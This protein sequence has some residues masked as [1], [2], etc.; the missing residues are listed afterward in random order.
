[1]FY[2]R[3]AQSAFHEQLIEVREW[4]RDQLILSQNAME[5]NFYQKFSAVTYNKSHRQPFSPAEKYFEIRCST[6]CG[7]RVRSKKSKA[8]L[9]SKTLGTLVL[10]FLLFELRWYGLNSKTC[11]ET[12]PPKG[13]A[14][15]DN[16][17]GAHG[18]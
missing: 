13:G 15:G 5:Q 2:S 16:D 12:G 18:L 1:M 17:R 8:A 7:A 3:A 4:Y 14:E 11:S 9:S 6:D 10:Q